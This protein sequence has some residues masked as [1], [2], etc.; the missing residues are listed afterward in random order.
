MR[1]PI[2]TA[3]PT[4]P[5]T[6]LKNTGGLAPL[7]VATSASKPARVVLSIAPWMA[8]HSH[9]FGQGPFMRTRTGRA[10]GTGRAPAGVGAAPAPS[11]KISAQSLRKLPIANAGLCPPR[12]ERPR[13]A[14]AYPITKLARC[15][16]RSAPSP[17]RHQDDAEIIDVGARRAGDDEIAEL[18]ES[19]VGVVV[20]EERL[21]ID[22]RLLGARDT[23]GGHDRAGVVLAAVY[24]VRVAGDG[25]HAAKTL[26]RQRQGEQK[27]R[28][29]A[30]LAGAAHGHR[31]LAARNNG[32]GRGEGLA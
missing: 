22:S 11:A 18:L 8:I 4:S 17:I 6:E 16:E 32:A 20:G 5:P 14:A 29:A 25:A 12:T 19:R 31:R 7:S 1:S 21:E 26:Q 9:F 15:G 13:A 10:G 23:V 3:G 24:A 2:R 27:F 28:V 30:A